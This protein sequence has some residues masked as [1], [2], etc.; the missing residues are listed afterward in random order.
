VQKGTSALPPIATSIALF[1]DN[2]GHLPIH[3]IIGES[4]FAHLPRD[5]YLVVR[6]QARKD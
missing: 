3:S 2:S 1:W 6:P 5:Y 4:T